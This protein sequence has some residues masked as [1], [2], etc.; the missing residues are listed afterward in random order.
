M[1]SRQGRMG[2]ARR[3]STLTGEHFLFIYFEV[4]LFFFL[5]L[6]FRYF[7][8]CISLFIT[9]FWSLYLS[10][11]LTTTSCFF[12]C[13]FVFCPRRKVLWCACDFGGVDP[14]I[15]TRRTIVTYFFPTGFMLFVC[16]LQLPSYELC[17]LG[18]TK[19]RSK[20]RRTTV[21]EPC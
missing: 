1:P 4:R 15:P 19:K 2:R 5:L 16:S 9:C 10:P 13:E 21:F 6:D 7:F 11:F 20:D 18:F 3:R 14:I 17:I 12:L 8:C